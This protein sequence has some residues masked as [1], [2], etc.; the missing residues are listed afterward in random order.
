VARANKKLAARFYQLKISH[1]LTGQYLQRTTR[2]PDAKCWW[3]NYKPQTREHLFKNCPISELFAN[4]RC[5]EAV[6]DFLTTTEV[7][8]AAGPPVAGGGIIDYVFFFIH[9]SSIER[10]RRADEV[11][12]T[13]G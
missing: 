2:R 6:P 8:R 1:C 3:C 11:T 4:E 13:L 10:R 7:G 5:S 9:M 12:G